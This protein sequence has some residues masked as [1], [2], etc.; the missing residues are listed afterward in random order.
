M[1]DEVGRDTN[2]LGKRW[3]ELD[4]KADFQSSDDDEEAA[5]D[6]GMRDGFSEAIQLMDVMTGGDGEYR[7]C[8][9]HDPERH[10]PTPYEMAERIMER[11]WASGFAKE[12]SQ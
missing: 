6:I 11:F 10:C 2:L 12:H 7:Y 1:T 5:F 8:T 3:A 4:I 9:D